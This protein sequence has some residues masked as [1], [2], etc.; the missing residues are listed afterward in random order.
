MNAEDSYNRLKDPPPWLM[1]LYQIQLFSDFSQIRA[2]K[3][4]SIE[5]KISPFYKKEFDKLVNIPNPNFKT[6]SDLIN[7]PAT[8]RPKLLTFFYNS[9]PIRAYLPPY[10]PD[11]IP[12][13]DPRLAKNLSA[14][15][16][17]FPLT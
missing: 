6:L 9:F 1:K 12:P 17:M 15:I 11:E 16:N 4:Q 10:N 14:L 13:P 7:D 3:W 5:W 8:T 2:E